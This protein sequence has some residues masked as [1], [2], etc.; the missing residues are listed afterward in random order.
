MTA[1]ELDRLYTALS[2]SLGRVGSERAP[3][4]L[5][6]FTL[7]LMT[8]GVDADLAMAALGRAEQLSKV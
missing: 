3:L 6:T 7:D 8:M 5:A 1:T 2:E 4:F